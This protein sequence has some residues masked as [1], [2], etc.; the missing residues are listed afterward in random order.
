VTSFHLGKIAN[1]TPKYLKE[2]LL[3][4]IVIIDRNATIGLTCNSWFTLYML[5]S[6]KR[7]EGIHFL[8]RYTAYHFISG[9]AY[10]LSTP[11]IA[12]NVP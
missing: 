8:A 9:W 12:V 1:L 5:Y 6:A 11:H 3:N 7:K 10:I 2:V 4:V